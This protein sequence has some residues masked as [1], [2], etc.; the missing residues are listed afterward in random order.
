[1]FLV[2]IVFIIPLH[3]LT[4]LALLLTMT[5]WT[6]WSHLGFELFPAA[7]PRHWLGKWLIGSTYHAI[8]HRK[9]VGHYGL[10]FTFWDRLFR[11]HDPNYDAEFAAIAQSSDGFNPVKMACQDQ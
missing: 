2:G 9:C 8:H 4:L 1:M 11:T 10:Y 7:F 5:V 6:V 3:F